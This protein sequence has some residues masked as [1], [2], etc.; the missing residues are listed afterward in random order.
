LLEVRAG[1]RRWPG[2]KKAEPFPAP[3]RKIEL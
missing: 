3:L 2:I 1:V